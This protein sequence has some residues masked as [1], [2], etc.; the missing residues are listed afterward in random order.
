MALPID[1]SV[2]NVV[3]PAVHSGSSA[4]MARCGALDLTQLPGPF[5]PGSNTGVTD[6]ARRPARAV[7]LYLALRGDT[8]DLV[9]DGCG[10]C[11]TTRRWVGQPPARSLCNTESAL[12]RISAARESRNTCMATSY[13]CA[14]AEVRRRVPRKALSALF[15]SPITAERSSGSASTVARPVRTASARTAASP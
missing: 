3:S 1:L 10:A 2:P 9:R 14:L 7:G 4:P 8:G 6:L 13:A 15:S 5:A 11:A 12:T